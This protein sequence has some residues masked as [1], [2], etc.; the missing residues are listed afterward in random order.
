MDLTNREIA[1]LIWLAAAFAWAC[2]NHTLRGAF[3]PLVKAMFTGPIVTVLASALAYIA[4]C[5]F[6][7]ERLGFWKLENSKTTLLWVLSFAILSVL[8]FKRLLEDRL[9]FRNV[10]REILSLTIILVFLTDTYTFG[11]IAELVIIPIATVLAVVQAVPVK[12]PEEKRAQ[13]ALGNL[14]ALLGFGYLVHSAYAAS[15]DW[16]HFATAS[17]ARD[18]AI[19][20]LLSLMF[21][22]FLY[23][24]R[25]YAT[26]EQVFAGLAFAIS[27]GRLLAYARFRSILAFRQDLDSL[28]RW[29]RMMN[30][31]QPTNKQAIKDSFRELRRLRLIEKDPP[32]VPPEEGWSPYAAKHFLEVEGIA[33][34]DYHRSFDNEWRCTSPPAKVS[35]GIFEPTISYYVTGGSTAATELAL[36]LNVLNCDDPTAGD[37][38][39]W[40]L[41]A[42]LLARATSS[43]TA[44][45]IAEAMGVGET[46]D[47][48]SGHLHVQLTKENYNAVK[49][50]SYERSLVI[51][52]WGVETIDGHD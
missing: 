22:P 8:D 26:Y 27:D 38:R 3:G 17:T 50:V 44:Q 31:G 33:T 36:E 20:I 45:E 49:G 19:P 16:T 6:A 32:P 34:D 28:K 4:L 37:E 24:L 7:L 42:I 10:L 5:I 40:R 11:L 21:L 52:R 25:L 41:A 2:S 47:V 46:A 13:Q 35:E 30:V 14:L 18:F 9:F 12:K 51:K 15:A 23:W 1:T 29:R 43:A 39:F 48:S